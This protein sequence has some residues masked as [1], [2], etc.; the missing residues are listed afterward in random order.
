MEFRDKGQVARAGVEGSFDLA[1]VS[2]AATPRKGLILK[3][4]EVN[5]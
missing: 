3:N 2:L 4:L 5:F 1:K